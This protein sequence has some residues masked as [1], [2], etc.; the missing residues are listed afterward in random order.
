MLRK[1]F[2]LLLLSNSCVQVASDV[3]SSSSQSPEEVVINADA[4]VEVG[5]SKEQQMSYHNEMLDQASNDMEDLSD[6]D[7]HFIQRHSHLPQKNVLSYQ[8][9]SILLHPPTGNRRRQNNRPTYLSLLVQTESRRIV[10][11][12]INDTL[13]V[14]HTIN[15]PVEYASISC[16][17]PTDTIASHRSVIPPTLIV[18]LDSGDILW[19]TLHIYNNGRIVA[20]D[21]NQRRKHKYYN[22]VRQ[23]PLIHRCCGDLTCTPKSTRFG[24]KTSSSEN[25]FGPSSN[26]IYSVP[27]LE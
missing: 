12:D 14:Y 8:L 9:W 25:P 21:G 15:I 17:Q 11:L 4:Q 19:L 10:L 24:L 5:N 3:D 1:I 6:F 7:K 16:V 2:F 13:K 22:R 26:I 27:R 18:F 23:R 20:G